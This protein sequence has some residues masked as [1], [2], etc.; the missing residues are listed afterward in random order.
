MGKVL[1]RRDIGE[2]CLIA[3]QRLLLQ[4]KQAKSDHLVRGR[5]AYRTLEM[6]LVPPLAPG[7]I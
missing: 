6:F 2:V 1:T 3:L 7:V 4:H 5:T